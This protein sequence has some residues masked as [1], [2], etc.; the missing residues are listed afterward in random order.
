MPC[1][2]FG[3]TTQYNDNK[4]Y[5]ILFYSI[6]FYSILCRQSN[7]VVAIL[8]HQVVVIQI[9]IVQSAPNFTSLITVMV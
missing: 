4:D 5:S 6:L 8:K 1:V 9:H 7:G 2:K 3:C